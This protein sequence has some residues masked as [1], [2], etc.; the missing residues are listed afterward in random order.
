MDVVQVTVMGVVSSAVAAMGA[1]RGV[2]AVAEEGLGILRNLSL[3]DANRVCVVVAYGRRHRVVDREDGLRREAGSRGDVGAWLVGCGHDGCAVGQCGVVWRCCVCG[4]GMDVVQ[5]VLMEVVSSAVAAMDAHRDLA[6]V[7][8]NFVCFLFN[9]SLA[10]VNRVCV[11]VE[12]GH[13]T[14]RIV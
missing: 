10:D 7:A 11:V 12:D 1:H 4:G 8:E 13:W 3:V 5:V 6:A 9:L 14:G 2:A